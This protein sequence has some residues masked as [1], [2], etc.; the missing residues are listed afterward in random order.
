M[1]RGYVTEGVLFVVDLRVGL[2]KTQKYPVSLQT[3][4]SF[5][6]DCKGIILQLSREEMTETAVVG[7][8]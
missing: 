4:L 6:T 2:T 1:R 8:T 7:C 5:Q 3:R